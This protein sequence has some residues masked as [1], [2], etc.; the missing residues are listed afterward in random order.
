[1]KNFIG[2]FVIFL[3]LQ[4]QAVYAGEEI[5]IAAAI[6][7]S[8]IEKPATEQS[9]SESKGMDPK[10]KTWAIVGGVVAVGVIA[11]VASGGGDSTTS[12]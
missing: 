12:H 5:N 8:A 9:S 1:M 11:A 2:T 3:V 10:T 4:A 6:G 7:A